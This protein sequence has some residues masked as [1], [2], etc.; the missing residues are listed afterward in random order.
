LKIYPNSNRDD[1]GV[2]LPGYEQSPSFILCR[3]HASIIKKLLDGNVPFDEWPT[4]VLRGFSGY[5]AFRIGYIQNYINIHQRNIAKTQTTETKSTYEPYMLPPIFGT[6]NT[7]PGEQKNF[8]FFAGSGGYRNEVV[9]N[10]DAQARTA[11]EQHEI[12]VENQLIAHDQSELNRINTIIDR[13]FHAGY[14]PAF[15]TCTNCGQS[16][17]PMNTAKCSW[18]GDF[19]H[20]VNE[21]DIRQVVPVYAD[22]TSPNES[23]APASPASSPVHVPSPPPGSTRPE[24]A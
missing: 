9:P 6:L 19:M 1:Q 12:N 5:Y 2:Y 16:E 21:V 24:Q 7:E 13:I 15:K 11:Q 10:P 14:S 23:N 8:Q 17:Q 4:Q 18:C 3:R 22:R 20:L